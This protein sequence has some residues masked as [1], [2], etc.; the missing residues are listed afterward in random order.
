MRRTKGSGVMV[1]RYPVFTHL[2]LRTTF[3]AKIVFVKRVLIS[4]CRGKGGRL[5]HMDPLAES[6]KGLDQFNKTHCGRL[7]SGE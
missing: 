4:F 7:C 3:D 1:T 2:Q 6:W 5:D